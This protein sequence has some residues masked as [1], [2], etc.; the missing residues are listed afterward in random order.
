MAGNLVGV[1]DIGYACPVG[2]VLVC[3]KGDSEGFLC[4]GGVDHGFIILDSEG[5]VSVFPCAR[6]Y[7]VGVWCNN[8]KEKWNKSGIIKK[9]KWNKSGIII[10]SSFA[11]G[12][13]SVL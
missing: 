11:V 4:E 3:V 7:R 6:R 9:E 2:L 13:E 5:V 12:I 8:R 10:D 1:I